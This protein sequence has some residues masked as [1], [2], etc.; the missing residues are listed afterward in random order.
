MDKK[1]KLFNENS[2]LVHYVLNKSFQGKETYIPG[3]QYDDIVQVG[4]IGLWRACL[5]FN[6][7]KNTKFSTYA[8]HL[9]RQEIL[10]AIRKSKQDKILN[11][12]VS[13]DTI[14]CNEDNNSTTIPYLDT[15]SAEFERDISLLDL[16]NYIY[17]KSNNIRT[18]NI[19]NSYVF[20]NMTQRA[21]GRK[22]GYSQP[23]ISRI[24][25][26]FKNILKNDF[27]KGNF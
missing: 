6:S 14:M 26:W 1:E 9:I 22:Y 12:S 21:I 27:E 8:Y 18:L 17:S 7:N 5:T 10:L 25:K 11:Q 3:Y 4:N 23:H 2:K 16:K 19:I 20:E 15:I 24:I 13:L